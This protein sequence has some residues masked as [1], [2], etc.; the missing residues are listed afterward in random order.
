MARTNKVLIALTSH[1]KLGDTGEETG[2]YVPEAAHPWQVFRQAGYEVD[3]VSVQ[4]G[5]PPESGYD[6]ED[7]VQRLFLE[8]E[9]ARLAVTP[10]A[11]EVN[12]A[13]YDAIFYA[14]GH[15][16]MWDFPGDEDL[17][18]L[19]R[20]IYE[21][22]GVVAAVCHGPAALVPL[23]LSDGTPLVAGKDIT[24]FTNSEE[25]AAG[26]TEI[27]P[28]LLQTTLEGLGARYH[29]APDFAENV[30]RDGRLVTGQNPASATGTAQ[31]VL[32][33]LKD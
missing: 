28:F 3:Y 8:S 26:A 4:G 19:G 18:A 24:G 27:V 9:R 30:V 23:T 32:A 7:E 10:K 12:A 16:T 13:D 20:D 6:A 31:G 29:V 1:D 21:N 2:Y 14:G 11:A 17:A 22:G 15:G 5:N 33:A 25:E